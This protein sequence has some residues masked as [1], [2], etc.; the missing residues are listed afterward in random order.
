M[1]KKFIYLLLL[2]PI[3]S[4]G[5]TTSENYIKNT[6]YINPTENGTDVSDDEKIE[7]I[8]YFDGLGRPKQQIASKTGGGKQATIYANWEQDWTPGSG[9]TG[10]YNRNGQASENNRVYGTGPNG[11]N[12]LLW[13]CTNDVERNA[14]G[15]WNTDYFSIDNTKTYIYT[16]WMKRTGSTTNGRTY[17]GTQRVMNLSGTPIGNPY[18]MA[19]FPPQADTWYL[20]VGK[21]H[22]KDY[23]GGDTGVSG[24]YDQNGN[25]VI[26]G[27]EFKW[28]PAYTTT[29]MRSYLYYSTDINTRQ[30]FWNPVVREVNGNEPSIGDLISESTPASL[31][32]PITYDDY[33]RQL[34]DYLPYPSSDNSL[35]FQEPNNLL[36]EL[37]AYY[38]T[39]FSGELAV[40]SPNPFSE[41][42]VEASPAGRL[43]KQAAPGEAWKLGEGHEIRMEYLANT[44]ADN[45]RHFSVSH[46]SN[47]TANIAFVDE[48]SY[49]A[50]LLYKTITKDENWQT[51]QA[52]AKDHTVEEFKNKS[53]QV[54]LKRTYN[55]NVAH[56]TYYVYD[57]FGNLSYV[58]S[59]EASK[60]TSISTTV[61]N[62]LCYQY[63]YDS[64]N[65]L[66]EKKIPGKGWEYI[67]YDPLD[68]PV[69]T[70][71][72]NLKAANK[73]LFT[74]YDALGRVAYTGMYTHSSTLNQQQMQSYYNTVPTQTGS[75]KLY[76]ESM[77]PS[78]HGSTY[79]KHHYTNYMF[80]YS[81]I[82][83]LTLNYYDTYV[84][85]RA[86][87]ATTVSAYGV[88]S[89]TN[90]KSLATGSKIKVLNTNHWITT[91]N[92]YDEK[93]RPMYGYNKNEY[94]NTVDVV[95][96][97][98]DFTGNP[99][100]ITSTHTKG[101]NVPITVVE[102]FT[103]DHQQRVTKQTHKVNSQTEEV[104]A[105]NTY[106]ELGRLS[107]KDVGNTETTPLQTVDYAYNIRGWLSSIND[108]QTNGNDLFG[109]ALAYNNPISGT[110]LFNG[111][112]SQTSWETKS[113]QTNT[114]PISNQ[115]TYSYDAL[116]RIIQA[117]DNTGNYSLGSNSNPITYD[118][119]GNIKTLY[120]KG[121]TNAS[122]TSFGVMDN[123]VYTYDSGNKL[124][125]VL[126]NGNDNYGF[127]DGINKAVEYVYDT[128][129]NMTQDLN[130]R[131]SN[132]KYNHL[133]LPTEVTVKQ[134]NN[135]LSLTDKI[136]YV[137][138]AIGTKQS[139]EV[140]VTGSSHN[141]VTQY[142][143]NYVYN[144]THYS[145]LPL[146]FFSH[147]EGYVE[148]DG[149]GD[150]EYTY[151][152]KDHLGNIRLAY[153]DLN[154]DG[155]ITTQTE[156]KEENNYYP[157]GLK[158]KGYNSVVNGRNHNYGFN[159]IEETDELG[160]N[161]LEMD[162]RKYDPA[163]ARWTSVDPITHFSLSTYNAFDNNP[164]FWAD[165][166]G[167][168][169]IYNWNTGQYKINERVVS[170]EEAVSYVKNKENEHNNNTTKEDCPECDNQ[171]VFFEALSIAGEEAG[172]KT[173]DGLIR[174][175]QKNV[176]DYEIEKSRILNNAIIISGNEAVLKFIKAT[177]WKFWE[178]DR[179]KYT[180]ENTVDVDGENISYSGE[181][182]LQKN[183][184]DLNIKSFHAPVSGESY[185]TGHQYHIKFVND[186][187][188]TIATIRF[189]S[190]NDLM[191]VFNHY[192]SDVRSENIIDYVKSYD[193]E[194]NTNFYKKI[195][196]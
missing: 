73:W 140:Q 117:S 30:Y 165:P 125:K 171:D 99:I 139:K 23:M 101:S 92:Y 144:G 124:I 196:N 186:S 51:G 123:L 49:A 67:V 82:D 41:K 85:N 14:D 47:N 68:R 72:A 56:D 192:Y 44:T 37:N 20:L 173:A 60:N 39:E 98:L 32:T 83:I 182:Y 22:P 50:N 89:T 2:Y 58:L 52:Y 103:Y 26:G 63:K 174:A 57:D 113:I 16:V 77:N 136:V 5:Q 167:A 79:V 127:K 163:I 3:W 120:R 88:N 15:G 153:A 122:A 137:Y 190:R 97:K 13:E 170:Y 183:I 80:P 76:Y 34:K 102:A 112:I 21:I 8:T 114:N 126:D 9:S 195:F 129:G 86:G 118:L 119:N 28:D 11:D 105:S 24:F 96:S 155:L 162:M 25:K 160:L 147:M 146:S 42:E 78:E 104:L 168:N 130:K 70:Q 172:K 62:E 180:F 181:I 71:D 169:S 128:N 149:N 133:N 94:L 6:I 166:S 1:M 121:H 177:K 145:G 110:A 159:G 111:N 48:G 84:F 18:F 27:S 161:I 74:K 158:H 95:K 179:D 66:I 100:E 134:N 115:Y 152:Y 176:T 107:S 135:A 69:L 151:Q 142:A 12:V 64:R 46:P 36:N 164:V 55:L 17:H 43:L 90:T 91:V 187:D 4:I 175:F 189:K 54:I 157:F 108:G 59:P 45:V 141:V 184:A 106:D 178:V 35:Q 143:G 19:T 38:I 188:K 10:F 53:G 191:K 31:V 7:T 109:F 193:E 138:D 29:R 81:N 87:S 154:G 116:N 93:G 65:R 156:I 131:I 75:P 33:G 150:Y 194:N 148:P 61:L 185:F 132:I 40:A